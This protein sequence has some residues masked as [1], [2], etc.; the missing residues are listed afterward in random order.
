MELNTE[1]NKVFGQEM[2]KL[3]S[4]QIDEEKLKAKAE[5]VWKDL[6]KRE[7]HWNTNESS[8]LERL[9]RANIVERLYEEV[10][11]LLKEPMN[12]EEI[13]AKA[14]RIVEVAK[15]E[16]E[17]RLADR[18]AHNMCQGY[19]AYNSDLEDITKRI[20]SNTENID[21]INQRR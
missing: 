19:Y 13:K 6:N 20:L 8:E 9:I 5:E 1:I 21:R 7:Y 10:K 15:E 14:K 4:A 11:L 17:V 2:A 3:F 16:A 12:E 18:I